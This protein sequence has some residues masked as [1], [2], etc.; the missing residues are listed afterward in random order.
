LGLILTWAFQSTE[1]QLDQGIRLIK[2][3]RFTEAVSLFNRIKQSSPEDARPYFFAG[4]ALT[5]SGRLTNAA[6]ELTEAVRL[7]PQHPEYRILQANVFARL[8]QRP[9][10][11]E[12]LEPLQKAGA[13]EKL[14]ASW[15]WLLVDSYYRVERFDDTLK[16]LDLMEKRFPDDPRLDLNRGQVYYLQSKF[17]L[18]LNAFRK[19]AAKHPD[20]ALVHFELGKLFYQRDEMA[21]AK[22]SLLE[23][24][25]LEKNNPKYLQKLG[26]VLLA[27]KNVDEAILYLE[28]GA[29]IDPNSIEINYSLGQA[30]HRKGDRQEAAIFMNKFQELKQREEQAGE[31]ERLLARG[32]RMLDESKDREARAVFEQ[33]VEAD[34]RNWTAHAYL[35]EMFLSGSDWQLARPHL[36][37]METL[38]AESVVGNY[39][40]ARYSY[41]TREF[42]NARAYAEKVRQARPAHA[43]LRNL[44][45]QIYVALNQREKAREEFQAAVR[46]APERADF[47]ENLQKLERHRE[48]E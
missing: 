34:P 33:V 42:E 26:A 8:K 14:D 37:K 39:L 32:E 29:A 31:L 48:Q 23:A 47:R 13:T 15:L 28:R 4:M 6:L 5:E 30:W 45:G 19:S 38:D 20:N 17:D 2:E 7:D 24:V 21:A 25:R 27:L 1:G 36:A 12:A 22:T 35:A 11:D 41:L 18:A 43:E 3:R 9:H 46:L 40:M 10:V 16:T 44:L